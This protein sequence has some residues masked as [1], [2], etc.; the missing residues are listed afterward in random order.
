[1]LKLIKESSFGAETW[2]VT[3]PET[4]IRTCDRENFL[5][6]PAKK[7]EALSSLKMTWKTVLG[8]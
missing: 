6:P 2:L 1:M 4:T 5:L 8:P 3:Q 7:M